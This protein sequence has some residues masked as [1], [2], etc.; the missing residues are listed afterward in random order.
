MTV[1]II[2]TLAITTFTTLNKIS[3]VEIFFSLNVFYLLAWIPGSSL[4]SG[5][6]K[7]FSDYLFCP[8]SLRTACSTPY[9]SP[10]PVCLNGFQT[11]LRMLMGMTVHLPGPNGQTNTSFHVLQLSSVSLI[12]EYKTKLFIIFQILCNLLR[13]S[14][15]VEPIRELH[16]KP[17]LFKMITIIWKFFWK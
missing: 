4:V 8:D 16:C 9:P 10:S 13:P 14:Y 5:L 6:Y 17:K 1:F 2:T 11:N 7:S 3:R 15:R 12:L